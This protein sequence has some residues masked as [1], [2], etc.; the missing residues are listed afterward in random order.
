[1]GFFS[2]KLT[3][4]ETKYSVYDRE[5]LAMYKGVKHF[6]HML[7]GRKFH[8]NT[9]H[10]PLIYSFLQKTETSSPR[11]N[12]HLDFVGQFTTDIRHISGD[13]NVVADFLSRVCQVDGSFTI[14]YAIIANE[15]RTDAELRQ[16][17][18]NQIRNSLQLKAITFSD[19]I[20]E[21]FCDVSTGTARPYIPEKFREALIKN[22]TDLRTQVL[23]L[24]LN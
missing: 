13:S 24:R 18:N 6:R 10:K 20:A 4:A 9:D 8:I 15:Q 14:D 5:L 3:V 1:M 12:R 11:Q 7:D 19:S 16:L 17:L 2:K 23:R 21:V 22:Y